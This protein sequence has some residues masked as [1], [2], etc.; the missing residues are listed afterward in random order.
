MM[1]LGIESSCDET[2]AAVVK[3]GRTVLSSVVASQVEFH[4]KYGGVVPEIASRKHIEAIGP[5]IREALERAGLAIEDIEGI[6]VTQGP[7]LV[8]SLLIGLSAAKAIAY[9]RQVPIV[10]VN[11]LEGH[12]TAIF[13][14]RPDCTFPFVGLVVSGGH[15]SIY[16]VHDRGE[17]VLLGQTR[18]DAAGEAFD[19]VAKLL[20][21]GYPGGVVID[22]MARE[23]NAHA[24]AFPRALS[25][26][27]SLDF[28]FSGVKT[29]VLRFVK[30]HPG[31]LSNQQIR[32]IV[33]SF[34]EAVVDVLVA[35][36]IMA[37]SKIGVDRIVVSGGVAANTRLREKM[38]ARSAQEQ[39]KLFIPSPALCTDNAAMIAAA[40]NYYLEQGMIAPLS[41]NAYS[42]FPLG[43]PS[44]A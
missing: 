38:E 15:T 17:Y 27:D 40:G 19:K 43:E 39:M 2:A 18:D 41:M 25:G 33:A 14:E 37:A 5:V 35:K 24:I 21:L 16:Q 42:R 7:G 28:S 11:H 29:A 4:R 30:D 20:G 22:R 23:G 12:L 6:A 8:G 9:V 44:G 26:G 32:D 13:L 36:V 10:G 34:Q 3:D 1:V 31:T